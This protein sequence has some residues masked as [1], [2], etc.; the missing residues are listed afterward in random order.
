TAALPLNAWTHLATAYDGANL[1]LYVNG[2]LRRT[3]AVTGLITVGDIHGALRIGG[4]NGF[5][6]VA[7]RFGGECLTGLIDEVK[8]YNRALSAA[9]INLD[10]GG[11]PPPQP[12]PVGGL[13]L[14]LSF[15]TDTVV[16]V[17][18]TVS[19]V[20]DASGLGNHGTV[21]GAV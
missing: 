5:P 14:N 1:R 16:S 10:M 13:V 4:N 8:V 17:A 3:V 9:E 15:D 19:T 11:T 12:T 21:N 7:G 6:D 20:S 2:V 18:T